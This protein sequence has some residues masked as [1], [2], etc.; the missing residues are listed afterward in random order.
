MQRTEPNV[1]PAGTSDNGQ[2]TNDKGQDLSL[3]L[4]PLSFVTQNDE[5]VP[6]L[7]AG[8]GPGP[9]PRTEPNA[10]PDETSDKGQRT[11]DKGQRTKDQGQSPQPNAAHEVRPVNGQ[12]SMDRKQKSKRTPLCA[13]SRPRGRRSPATAPCVTKESRENNLPEESSFSSA[14]E[15]PFAKRDATLIVA[16]R[17]IDLTTR[18]RQH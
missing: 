7:R 1:P 15:R 11:N 14:K 2:G 10:L 9:I 16:Q 18:Q 4:G 8:H 6:E 13:R 12:Q 3:V 17:L 5:T